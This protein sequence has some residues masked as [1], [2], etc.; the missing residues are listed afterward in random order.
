MNC[1]HPALCAL[2][3]MSLSLLLAATCHAGDGAEALSPRVYRTFMPEAG[4]SAFAVELSPGVSL[5]YDPLRGGINQIWA[6]GVDLSPTFQ[7]KINKPAKPPGRP[8][9]TE[10]LLHPLRLGEAAADPGHRFKGYRYEKNMVVFEFTLHG[11]PVTESLRLSQDGHGVVRTFTLPAGGGPAFL[12]VEPQENATV[13]LEGGT[14][15]TPGK[16][17]F[18]EGSLFTVRISP[19]SDI[20]TK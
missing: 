4:P 13:T 8:F 15:V 3:P 2:L 14:E 19:A 5:C 6:G 17:R 9:Y 18:A 16:W 1:P 11:L 12:T 20:L 7:A 10:H